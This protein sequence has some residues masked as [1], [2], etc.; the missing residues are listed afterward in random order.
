MVE[1]F[2]WAA[3]DSPGTRGLSLRES[4]AALV[5]PATKYHP[6]Q[7]TQLNA[8]DWNKANQGCQLAPYIPRCEQGAQDVESER[9][10]WILRGVERLVSWWRLEG[11]TRFLGR[12]QKNQ[13]H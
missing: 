3:I 8:P 5:N 11:F 10:S 7:H 1:S 6:H 2:A 9:S 13:D 12:S 4:P